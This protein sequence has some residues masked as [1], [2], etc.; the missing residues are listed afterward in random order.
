M[1]LLSVLFHDVYR[2]EPSESGFVG[3]GADRYKLTVEQFDGQLSAL[4]RVRSDKPILV[5]DQLRPPRPSVPFAITVD[6]GGVSYYTTVAERLE[7]LD[8]RGHC[9]TTTGA[10]GQR[11]FLDRRQIRE[12]H[13]RG[14]LIGSHSV[15]H[16]RRFSACTRD[17]MV[18]EWKESRETLEDI[19]GEA[20]TVGSVP[21]GYYSPAVASAACQA[22]LK[23][24]FT[25]EPQTIVHRVAGCEVLGRFTIRQ[26]HRAEFIRD[27][28]MLEASTLLRESIVWNAKKVTKALLGHAYVRF[29]QGRSA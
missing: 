11:G 14:H 7:T 24:L 13:G 25:S 22:G 8:W 28:G 23:V 20:V 3:R 15:S 16:P 18:R 26:G 12:L 2:Q 1:K 17:A 27:L 5:T 6:D 21:G 29:S 10:V 19:V 4:A 9:L